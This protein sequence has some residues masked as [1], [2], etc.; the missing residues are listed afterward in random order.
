[1][2]SDFLLGAAADSYVLTEYRAVLSHMDVRKINKC[3]RLIKI[4][5]HMCCEL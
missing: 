1:M 3:I 4:K 2:I 5:N